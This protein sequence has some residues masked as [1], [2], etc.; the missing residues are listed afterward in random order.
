MTE[1]QKAI[2][3]VD[4]KAPEPTNAQL[5]AQVS[6]LEEKLNL[7]LQMVGA[8]KKQEELAERTIDRVLREMEEGYSEEQL[9]R[10]EAWVKRQMGGRLRMQ[11][12]PQG[13]GSSGLEVI[14]ERYIVTEADREAGKTTAPDGFT[15]TRTISTHALARFHIKLILDESYESEAER[16]MAII[17]DAR[18]RGNGGLSLQPELE[19]LLDAN[20]KLKRQRIRG[21]KH[22]R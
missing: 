17:L 9:E 13:K 19:N 3:S 20:G 2:I 11:K 16:L 5:Q 15:I 6:G 10:A 8:P 18:E 22:V 21:R 1:E 7:V 12:G 4:G 14:F